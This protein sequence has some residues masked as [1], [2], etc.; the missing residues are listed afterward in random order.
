MLSNLRSRL[1]NDDDGFT[2]IE[3][4]VVVLIIAILLA[5][6]IPTFLSAQ[7]SAKD[8]SAQS[9]VRN[10]ITAVRTMATDAGGSLDG[11][12]MATLQPNEPNI[13]FAAAPADGVQVIAEGTAPAIT[14]VTLVKESDTGKFFAASTDVSGEIVQCEAATA[15]A[16]DTFNECKA[17]A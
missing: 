15:A 12:T 13:T 17:L 2:L 3:L 1:R 7:N 11:I 16:V 8:K 5:I 9:D 10:G 14:A 4:M 6:A